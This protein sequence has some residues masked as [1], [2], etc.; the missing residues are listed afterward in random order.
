MPALALAL[1]IMQSK[2][3]KITSKFFL[4]SLVTSRLA[5]RP[6]SEVKI[7]TRLWTVVFIALII[8]LLIC[9]NAI[10][11][12]GPFQSINRSP[13]SPPFLHVYVY[14]TVLLI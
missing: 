1:R 9:N 2:S 6:T 8:D 4:A 11:V 7:R 3:H 10:L 14:R 13:S 12:S 5:S